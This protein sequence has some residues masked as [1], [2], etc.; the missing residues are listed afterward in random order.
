M[1]C[2]QMQHAGQGYKEVTD[3]APQM[4]FLQRLLQYELRSAERYR[5]YVTVVMVKTGDTFDQ[6]SQVLSD[7]I[8]DS[9]EIE[10]VE[11]GAAILMGDTDTDGALCAISRYKQRCGDQLD[12]RFSI[13]TFPADGREA[14]GLLQ[15]ASRRLSLSAA[16][17]AGAVVTTG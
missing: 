15:A 4:S 2:A 11:D 8:R 7:T 1:N 14:N 5:R 6:L 12:M 17:G 13:A 10:A 9:D 3:V 16:A